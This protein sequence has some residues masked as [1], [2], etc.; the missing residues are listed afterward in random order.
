MRDNFACIALARGGFHAAANTRAIY[1]N[2]L[3]AEFFTD[4]RKA[5]INA[6]II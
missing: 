6:I 5:C 4:F 2:A 1:H 3:L